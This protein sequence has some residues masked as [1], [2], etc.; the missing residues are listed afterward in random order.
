MTIPTVLITGATGF[1]GG[2]ATAA[3]LHDRPPCRVL[4]LLRAA[5]PDVAT[6]RLWASLARFAEPALL[7]EGLRRCTVI[8]ADLTDPS[9]LA[10][11]RLDEVTHVL[12]LAACTSF[13]SVRT[14][15][16]VNVEGTLA[17]AQRLHRAA[18]LVRFLYVGTAYICGADAPQVVREDDYPR[19]GVRHLVE[20]T[21]TKAECETLLEQLMPKLPLVVA[22][23]S[24]VVGHTRLGCRPSASIFWYYRS[25]YLLR[26]LPGPPQ[27]RK[28]I[29]PV[30]YAA[31]ALLRLL[32]KP[33]LLHRRYH[34][35]AGEGA[36]VSW[37]EMMAEFGR[38]Y[39]E[40]A[41][42]PLRVV[43]HATLLRERDRL[44]QRLGP[45]DEEHLLKALGLYFPLSTCGAEVFNNRRLLAEGVSP[46][47]R[48]TS[49]LRACA[50][51]PP[52]GTVYEQMRDD[53]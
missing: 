21:R 22:R 53:E 49:Y 37:Q 42:E 44:R 34:V 45:G 41:E 28:D 32:F 30:D 2:A 7:E 9:T 47:P 31:E 13:V 23:P 38:C 6:A 26:R 40:P 19:P 18:D 24:V 33:G 52:A 46:P 20:Y 11:H 43:D 27:T 16:R 29:I 4:L 15:R 1:I 10:D 50:T 36:A 3:L 17:L 14:V 25:L 48:F 51:L 5:T 12:H 35:S 39:R 8:P